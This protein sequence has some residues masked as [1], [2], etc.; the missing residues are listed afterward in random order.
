MSVRTFTH[1]PKPFYLVFFIEIWERFGYY[2]VQALLVLYMVQ[3]LGFQDSH[4][5]FLFAAFSALVFLFPCLGGYVGDKV[6][7]TKRTI[8]LGAVILSIGYLLL[9]IPVVS[10][11]YLTL[12]LAWIAVGVGLF[13]ANPSSLLSKVY[14]ETPYN[15]D[16]GFTLYYMAINIGSVIS[17]NLTPI[18]NRFFGWHI[19]FSVCFA[20]L[21]I[22]ILNYF[23]MRK[24]VIN[25]GSKP[26]QRSLRLDYFAYVL[27]GTI[28]LIGATYFLLQYYQMVSWLL[29]IGTVIL[30]LV[31]CTLTAKAAPEERQG[32][33]LFII[34]FA[35]GVVFFVSYFQMPTSLSLFALRNV[36]HS[37]LGIPIQPAQF[38][39][40]NPFWVM[41]MSPVMA[42]IYQRMYSRN[43]DLS[44]PAKF[45]LGTFLSGLAFLVLPIGI[46][47]NHHGIIS[48][49][50]LVLFYWLQ[51]MGELLVSALGLSLV[52]RFVP[53]R[54]MGFTMG[55]WFL[56]ASIAS[57]IAG[58]VA[59]IASIPQHISIDPYLSLSI[60][61]HLFMKIGIITIAMSLVMFTLAPAL[62]KLVGNDKQIC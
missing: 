36:Y 55:L 6:L 3:R 46:L 51:S 23:V 11:T 45:S 37:I 19:A 9:S 61:N 38:Q 48:G 54:F 47:F 13:K 24:T 10:K 27:M 39:M 20:G 57:I 42:L 7:G 28:A 4:A 58:R 41:T 50:W 21:V 40:L 15:L 33:L 52:A 32:M 53:Q 59:S 14:G 12:P 1:Q 16:S 22:A 62:K 5:D 17:M 31:Y 8:L 25:Y 30:L 35:Q 18:L 44:L 60:Y 34:L 43:C 29:P 26:D 56:C 2:G 49:I